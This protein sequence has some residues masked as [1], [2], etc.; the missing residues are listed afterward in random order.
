MSEPAHAPMPVRIRAC[1]PTDA[2]AVA[3]AFLTSRATC[4]PWLPKV[5]AD[6]DV[7]AWIAKVLVVRP[8]VWVAEFEDR[9][10]GFAA[11]RDDH[12]DHLYVHPQFHNRGIGTAL[13]RHV[14]NHRPNGLKLWV[15]QQNAQ[16]RRFYERHGFVLLHETD[17]ATNEERTPDALYGWTPQS[18]APSPSGI[19]QG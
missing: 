17:G 19:G 18:L 13:L 4:L 14:M 15:F 12:V 8:E 16:A 6:A 11:L 10:V 9:V 5:H 3:D 1:R 7:R 2:P